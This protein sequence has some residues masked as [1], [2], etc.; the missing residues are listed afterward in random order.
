MRKLLA[1]AALLGVVAAGPAPV[2]EVMGDFDGDGRP[3][4]VQLAIGPSGY[5]IS[6]DGRA[7][8]SGPLERA[9]DQLEV[10]PPGVYVS[11]N[12]QTIETEFEVISF[13]NDQGG[14][15]ITY[16]SGAGYRTIWVKN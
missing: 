16:W 6:I 8:S 4:I 2:A 3:D 9:G 5:Q 12:G 13:T 7:V 11:I 1:M 15:S 14:E 10:K